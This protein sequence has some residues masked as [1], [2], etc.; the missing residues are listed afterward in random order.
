ML[1]AITAARYGAA[2]V[3]QN[4]G[5]KRILISVPRVT[6]GA[7]NKN[8]G[9]SGSGRNSWQRIQ[10]NAAELARYADLGKLHSASIVLVEFLIDPRER[11]APSINTLNI[12]CA[13][14]LCQKIPA[15]FP[16]YIHF[17]IKED[18]H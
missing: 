7:K 3:T 18:Y 16:E 5:Q 17:G 15:P 11:N 12:V 1:I 14:L 4:S 6:P 8:P 9:D 13:L 2:S 10:N